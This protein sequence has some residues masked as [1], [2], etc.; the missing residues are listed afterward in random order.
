VLVDPFSAAAGLGEAVAAYAEMSSYFQAL[1]AERR[2]HPRED[3][4]SALVAAEQDGQRLDE[5]ELLALTALILGAG[6]E[7]TTNLI[8]NSVLAL[9]RNPGER[10]RLQ[11]DPGLIASA[12][13]EF[14]RWD[15]PVQG[16]DRVASEDCEIDGHRIAKGTFVVTLLGAAN[17]DPARFPEPD[18]LDLARGDGRHVSFGQGIHFCLGAHLAR[19]E[20]QIAVEALLRRFPDLDGPTD[21][22]DWVASMVLRGPTALPL[23]LG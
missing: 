23:S 7:T 6:H 11:D 9:L 17:R 1:F 8:G 22:P 16:T 18:R 5:A 15:S 12:V 2:R 13:E 10:K 3:L 20:A 4:L 21:P 19:V 14:L